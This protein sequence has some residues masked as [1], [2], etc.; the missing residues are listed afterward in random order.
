MNIE[1]DLSIAVHSTTR[2]IARAVA[3]I[4]DNNKSA[5]RVTVIAHNIAP[6]LIQANLGVWALDDRVRMLTLVDGIASAAGPLNLGLS[7]STAPFVAVMGSDDELE[8]G[9]ID[10]WLALLR[11]SGSAAIIA[12]I[13]HVGRGGD[14]YPPVRPGRSRKLDPVKDRLAYRSA[15][16][17]LIS[18]ETFGHLRFTE[19]L[20]SG[21][22]LAY[23]TRMWFS[24]EL[25]AFDRTGPAYIGH[26]D[27]VDRVSH[28]PR[29][30]EEDF[31]F[32]DEILPSSWFLSLPLSHRRA[33]CVKLI[34]LQVFD[35]V[36][37]RT[38][39]A[40]WQDEE[41]RA[42]AGVVRRVLNAA[43]R[44]E[45]LL[46]RADRK[47]LAVVLA[48]VPNDTRITDL[49]RRRWDYRTFAAALPRNIFYALHRQ[50][51]FRTLFAGMLVS[52]PVDRW[53]VRRLWR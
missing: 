38:N 22:D 42:L 11:T 44:V 34:R 2:P 24:G 27:A 31:R 20:A 53:W 50:G 51:P 1:V 15:P 45:N 23:V 46:S 40:E 36:L 5:I 52:A 32:L 37:A 35:A 29:T 26:H 3:S 21:E 13:F 4:L 16:L 33:I 6:E 25:I 39:A 48:A 9:A 43:P 7:E 28:V 10:S 8:T 47:T 18:R 14:A 49:L 19:G 41:R 12:R 30:V 17:G